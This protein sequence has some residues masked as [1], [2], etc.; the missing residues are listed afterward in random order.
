MV[1]EKVNKAD[2]LAY[3]PGLPKRDA[4]ITILKDLVS[5]QSVTVNIDILST[6]STSKSNILKIT[7]EFYLTIDQESYAD[8]IVGHIKNR[9]FPKLMNEKALER[10][11]DIFT[12]EL[13]LI[14]PC[15]SYICIH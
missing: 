8:T 2:P 13:I 1:D 7:V 11:V 4:L 15:M 6:E 5:D 3:A 10:N 9:N 12:K 14:Y